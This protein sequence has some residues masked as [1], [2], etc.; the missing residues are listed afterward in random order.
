VPNA[1]TGAPP[2]DAAYITLNVVDVGQGQGLPAFAGAP[3]GEA[4]QG[5]ALNDM[6]IPIAPDPNMNIFMRLALGARLDRIPR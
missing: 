2:S 1:V 6:E 5:E 3:A 4:R